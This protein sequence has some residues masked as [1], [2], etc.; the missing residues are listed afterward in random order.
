MRK[1]IAGVVLV[2]TFFLVSMPAF[3]YDQ[4]KEGKIVADIVVVRPL[5]L[6]ATILGTAGLIISLPFTIPS[7]SVGETAKLLVAEPFLYTFTRPVGNFERS[8]QE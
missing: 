7:G 3:A 1:T 2:L 5:S 8:G 4:D 6:A